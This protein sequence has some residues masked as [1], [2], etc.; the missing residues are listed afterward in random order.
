MRSSVGPEKPQARCAPSAL[1]E[2]A[3]LHCRLN[4]CTG[5]HVWRPASS[6]AAKH[7]DVEVADFLAQ[8][9]AVDPEQVSGADL[10]AA[11]G[12]ERHRQERML[13][14]TQDTVI[15]AGRRLVVATG[16]VVRGEGSIDRC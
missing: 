3:P 7:L 16:R 14:L 10:V 12:R 1:I 2:K 15:E 5:P 4:D 6:A 11:R 13:D 8:G 9:V